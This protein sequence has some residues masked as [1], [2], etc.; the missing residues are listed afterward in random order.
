MA[1]HELVP[2]QT[3]VANSMKAYGESPSD[4]DAACAKIEYMREL[5]SK[6]QL[7]G[8]KAQVFVI[9]NGGGESPWSSWMIEATLSMSLGPA[10]EKV[11]LKRFLPINFKYL[12]EDWKSAMHLLVKDAIQQLC[13]AAFNCV[14]MGKEPTNL[15]LVKVAIAER[16]S[17]YL[18][19]DK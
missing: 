2:W 1:Q 18:V 8:Y 13:G 3:L 10:N 16:M 12:P 15:N 6:M 11:F 4:I 9:A 7:L 17:P 14:A 19:K 5:L